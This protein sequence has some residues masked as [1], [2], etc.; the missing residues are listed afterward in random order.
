MSNWLRFLKIHFSLDSTSTLEPTTLEANTEATTVVTERFVLTQTTEPISASQTTINEVETTNSGSEATPTS[1]QRFPDGTS[2]TSTPI[3][4][5]TTIGTTIV[6]HIQDENLLETVPPPALDDEV[7]EKSFEGVIGST[8]RL[9][10]NTV[11]EDTTTSEA[12]F[13]STL[14][15]NDQKTDSYSVFTTEEQTTRVADQ[16]STFLDTTLNLPTTSPAPIAHDD[17]VELTLPP[18]ALDDASNTD[19]ESILVFNLEKSFDGV[20]ESTTKQSPTSTMS[21]Q[22]PT[23]NINDVPTTIVTSFDTLASVVNDDASNNEDSEVLSLIRTATEVD[24]NHEEEV[25]DVISTTKE[26]LHDSPEYSD[27]NEYPDT[28]SLVKMLDSAASDANYDLT[29][30]DIEETSTARRKFEV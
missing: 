27:M 12:S 20:T 26:V 11:F 9:S 14:P 5:S 18:P 29:I 1:M 25:D 19:E 17:N 23:T 24:E 6:N 13:T 16:S 28:D 22:D 3:V 2:T 8:T 7:L 15:N 4:P 10:S 21:T 30:S